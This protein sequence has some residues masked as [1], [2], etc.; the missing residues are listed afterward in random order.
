MPEGNGVAHGFGLMVC[1]SAWR[2]AASVLY[3]AARPTP[4]SSASRPS[5]L[6]MSISYSV[7]AAELAAL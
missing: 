4:I 5:R 3:S 1:S 6:E 2:P 7:S